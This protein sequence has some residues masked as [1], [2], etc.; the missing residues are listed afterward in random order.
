[1]EEGAELQEKKWEEVV[2]VATASWKAYEDAEVVVVAVVVVVA[3]AVEVEVE[4]EVA[5]HIEVEVDGL[6]LCPPSVHVKEVLEMHLEQEDEPFDEFDARF[7]STE[8]GTQKLDRNVTSW[9]SHPLVGERD[10]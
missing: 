6:D 3:A 7:D 2:V 4:V 10:D 1:M 9:S 5:E 8:S